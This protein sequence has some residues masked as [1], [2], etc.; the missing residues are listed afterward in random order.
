MMNNMNQ[1]SR[2]RHFSAAETCRWMAR[3]SAPVVLLLILL[4]R[5]MPALAADPLAQRTGFFFDTIITVSLYDTDDESILD[6]CFSDMNYYE[7][8]FSR[9]LEGSDVWNINHSEG[10][11]VEVAE[12][13]LDIVG[14]ALYY[15]ELSD[16]AFD[17]TIAPVVD[18][19][20]FTSLD[21]EDHVLP[22]EDELNEAL[23]HVDFNGVIVDREA[24]TITLTDPEAEIDLGGIAKGYISARI[25]EKIMEL[26]SE[27]ALINLGGNIV[28][29]GSRP[30]GTDW[31]IGIRRPFGESA[32]DII[33]V[34]PASDKAVITSGTYERYFE[35]DGVLYHHILDPQTGYSVSNGLSSV[36]ILTEDATAG[37]ALS[38]ACFILGPEDGMALIEGLD[39]VEALF[40]DES[41]VLTASS[42]WP[43]DL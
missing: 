36:T 4:V 16:G 22:D 23:T 38:T 35:L 39:G 34:V 33:A 10:S 26:G 1:Y 31:K 6:E 17:I 11:A 37:D 12:D 13:T 9:T 15:C 20:D 41:E 19:W 43:G 5:T 27:S 40:I 14:Q 42:G 24:G 2:N 29:V 32:Y 3:F 21:E 18:L 25:R 7:S 8:I 30:D 28:G